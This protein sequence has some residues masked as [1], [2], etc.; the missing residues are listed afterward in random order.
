MTMLD[1]SVGQPAASPNVAR[2][3]AAGLSVVLVAQCVWLLLPE[4]IRPHFGFDRLY[5]D[6]VSATSAANQSAANLAAS[7]GVIRG[8]LWAKSA[9]TEAN[10]LW[11]DKD[12]DTNSNTLQSVAYARTNLDRALTDSPHQSG[13]SLFLADLALRF[14]SV[15]LDPGE[16]LRM[17]YYTGASDQRLMPLRLRISA[18]LAK[19]NDI[20]IRQLVG[21]DI[22]LLLARKQIAE[23]ADAYA[24]ALPAAKTF[25]EQTV[26][27]VDPKAL[28]KV[29]GS[30]KIQTFPE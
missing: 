8:D 12:T 16:P 26:Q 1:G 28:D 6:K 30:G 9:F 29:R 2:G 20:E 25:I 13:P 15:G 11:T 10:L 21:R 24:V 19:F 5:I 4:I 18:Q 3:I 17:S 14:S 23:I 22:R 7:F 27:D